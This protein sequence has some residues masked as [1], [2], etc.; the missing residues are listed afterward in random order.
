MA[1]LAIAG[2]PPALNVLTS[3]MSSLTNGRPLNSFLPPFGDPLQNSDNPGDFI[4]CHSLLN[5][6]NSSSV[7]GSLESSDPSKPVSQI[8][9]L[10]SFA[11]M[12]R[13]A[14]GRRYMVNKVTSE[15]PSPLKPESV[16]VEGVLPDLTDVTLTANVTETPNIVTEVAKLQKS[17]KGVDMLYSSLR[18]VYSVI[19]NG[20]RR[21]EITDTD[22]Q[23][24]IVCEIHQKIIS[25]NQL[26]KTF[27]LSALDV[28]R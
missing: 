2:I 14:I 18:D 27:S 21:Y 9:A 23:S 24:R 1:P 25:R 26:L 7:D 11:K 22:C 19:R 8:A 10:K 28:L 3:V 15:T 5:S 4:N 13:A 17:L 6:I 12:F 16:D 20:L